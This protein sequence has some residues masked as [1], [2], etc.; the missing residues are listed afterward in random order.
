MSGPPRYRH[1]TR[2]AAVLAMPNLAT[3]KLRRAQHV[4]T[5]T[6]SRRMRVLQRAVLGTRLVAGHQ[7]LRVLQM[8]RQFPRTPR[9]ASAAWSTDDAFRDE[10]S[11]VIRIEA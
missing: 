6:R 9:G 4:E 11:V 8:S 10:L 1:L 2:S 3:Q 5:R 7:R